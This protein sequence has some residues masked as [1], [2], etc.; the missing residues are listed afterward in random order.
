MQG[1]STTQ[2][3]ESGVKSTS[4]PEMMMLFVLSSV[5]AIVQAL[6]VFGWLTAKIDAG[7]VQVGF[8]GLDPPLTSIVFFAAL[9]AVPTALATPVCMFTHWKPS[10]VLFGS[11]QLTDTLR[12]QF[13]APFRMKYLYGVMAVV[14]GLTLISLKYTFLWPLALNILNIV[15][16]VVGLGLVFKHFQNPNVPTDLASTAAS[17]IGSAAS[18]VDVARLDALERNVKTLE[19]ELSELKAQ[20]K[21]AQSDTQVAQSD[22]SAVPKEATRGPLPSVWGSVFGAR[23][24]SEKEETV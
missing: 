5:A 9:F 14:N 21:A 19:K 16:Y 12:G 7:I 15:L 20:L 22:T 18:A 6:A 13:A 8:I 23:A 3:T 17:M 4:T 11:Q 1:S 10:K 2:N 24:E